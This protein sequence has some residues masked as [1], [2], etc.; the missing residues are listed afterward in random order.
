MSPELEEAR[1]PIGD[2]PVHSA[3]RPGVKPHLQSTSEESAG[4]MGQRGTQPETSVYR[5]TRRDIFVAYC[6]SIR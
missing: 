5:V 3:C 6:I 4:R 1:S 2:L